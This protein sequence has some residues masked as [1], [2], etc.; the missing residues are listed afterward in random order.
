MASEEGAD[1]NNPDRH[2]QLR[3][4]FYDGN[5]ETYPIT[6]SYDLVKQNLHSLLISKLPEKRPTIEQF[7]GTDLKYD[8]GAFDG[9]NKCLDDMHR[10]IDEMF[11]VHNERCLRYIMKNS[12]LH[13]TEDK[14]NEKVTSSNSK[15]ED[16]SLQEKITDD[17]FFLLSTLA[18]DSVQ[19]VLT[20]PPY[21]E[22]GNKWDKWLDFQTFFWECERVLKPE[23]ALVMT[24]S[25]KLASK[26][27]PMSS[28]YKYD[29]V[30]VKDNGTNVVAANHQ[31]LRIHEMILVFGKQ[32]VTYTP[33]GRY[34]KYN[35]QKTE[36]KAYTQV[37]GRQSSNWKGGK[38][39]GFET[40]NKGD[41][42]PTTVNKWIR[43]KSKL[44]PTQKPLAMFEW[45]V[46]TYSDEGDLVIDP[47][48]GSGTTLLAAQ[49]LKREYLGAEKLDKYR[50][51]IKERLS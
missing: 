31:P 10:V 27:I 38:V 26:L 30:W 3:I 25:T 45:L 37:S 15:S 2:I 29:L 41:R 42:H 48:A 21:A 11:E 44:H 43:D 33:N 13:T 39:E 28:M 50:E 35:P 20:D 17:C 49:N 7:R 4:V 8:A 16:T 46:R 12:K 14:S 6:L 1:V 5:T 18:N 36:G 47:F 19:L 22:T 24:A 51:I 23:G 32:A 34:M 9:Y 40:V